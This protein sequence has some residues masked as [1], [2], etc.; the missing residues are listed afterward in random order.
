[1]TIPAISAATLSASA[2][3]SGGSTL[4]QLQKKLTDLE[5]QQKDEGL[6][7]TDDAKT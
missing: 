2:D 4:S 6:N 3:G 5:K 1:M 7:K